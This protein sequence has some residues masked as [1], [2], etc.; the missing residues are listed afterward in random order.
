MS[1]D[2]AAQERLPGLLLVL[3][4]PSGAGKTTLA[5][6]LR[7]ASPD[8]VFSISATTRAPRGA[9]REGVDYHFVTAERFT[10]LVAQGAFAEWA[11]VHG[12]RYGTLRATVDEALAAGKLALFDIDVQGGAQIKAAWPQQAAT[13]LVLPPDEAELERRLRGRDTDSDETIRRRLVAA[14][15]EVARG[16]GS[17]DYVVVNDVLEG[18]LAQLQAIVRHERLRHAGRWD[19]EAARVAEACRRSAAPLGGWAS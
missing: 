16:L 4:A 7:E 17:Y 11:E 14:R 3:S 5:H 10:E 8:A 12:Q 1:S 2:A 9:E 18:A 15:A 13:V 6:R 19:P